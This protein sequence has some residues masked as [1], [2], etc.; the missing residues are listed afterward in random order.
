MNKKLIVFCSVLLTITIVSVAFAEV[1]TITFW[2]WISPEWVAT[3]RDFEQQYPNI[4]IKESLISEAWAST[5][6]KFLAAVAGGNAPDASLMNSHEFPHFASLGVFYDLTQFIKRDKI[7]GADWFAPQWRGAQFSGKQFALPGITDTRV[8]YWNK[9]LFKSAGL[10]PD[11]PP[12]TGKDLEEFSSKLVKKDAGGNIIQ[13]GFIPTIEI[14]MPGA[15]NAFMWCWLS[16]TGAKWVSSDGK[17]YL[18]NDPKFVEALDWVVKFYDKYCG[19]AEKA[20]AFLQAGAGA[21]QDPFLTQKLAI[22]VDGDWGYFQ[23]ATIPDLDVGVAYV[24]I[25]D[26]P[27][28]VRHTFSCGSMYAISANTKHPEE[29]WTFIKWLSGPEGAKAYAKN[30]LEQRKKDWAR[31]QLPGEPV[32]IPNLFNNRQ[33]V[34][35]L[36]NIYLPLLPTKAKQAYKVITGSLNHTL[37]CAGLTGTGWGLTGL[38]FYNEMGTAFQAAIYHKMTPK[39]A[40][41]NAAAVLNKGLEE[42]WKQVKVK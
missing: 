24:P 4:K 41:D 11:K 34:K 17:K 8:T 1:T 42:A 30:A 5:A 3:Y 6:E 9:K 23:M 31:Q 33:A 28:A 19:G 13:Y 18:V 20:S 35:E 37:S 25:P 15:G 38:A 29:A 21:A 7:S 16:S 26:M 2:G 22:K 36:E 39:E 32:Y 40:L 27:G 14:G 12:A 10:N